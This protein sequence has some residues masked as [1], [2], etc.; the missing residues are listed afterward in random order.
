MC[1]NE[2]VGDARNRH[3]AR[4]SL[5][6]LEER[7]FFRRKIKKTEHRVRTAGDAAVGLD[8]LHRIL[9]CGAWN[10]WELRGDLLEGTIL[11]AVARRELPTC[12]PLAAD[13]AF[14]VINHEWPFAWWIAD[15][16]FLTPWPVHACELM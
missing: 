13:G 2:T 3:E 6:K 11:N 15:A 14:A 8:Q 12:D 10:F 7:A 4:H 16:Q 9:K 1:C 5:K